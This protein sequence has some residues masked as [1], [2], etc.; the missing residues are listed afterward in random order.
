MSDR[1]TTHAPP[2]PPPERPPVDWGR[3][4]LIGGVVVLATFL[5]IVILSA[6]LPR[7]WAVR[8]GN[9]VDQSTVNGIALGLFYGIVFTFVPLLILWIGFRRR[10]SWT[11]WLA[12]LVGAVLVATPNLLTLSIVVGRG[13]AAH[14]GDRIMD[15]QANY[16][17]ASTLV[18][19]IIAALLMALVVWTSVSRRNLTKRE[20]RLREERAAFDRERSGEDAGGSD[21]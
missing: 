19:A 7:W 12:F 14:A 5:L 20:R 15:T 16:F 2:P 8:I 9:Q 11:A 4:L 17:R 6:F 10:R 1:T 18:G 21:G 13:N 3:R